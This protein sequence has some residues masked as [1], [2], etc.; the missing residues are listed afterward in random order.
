MTYNSALSSEFLFTVEYSSNSTYVQPTEKS[1][2]R[3]LNDV[4]KKLNRNQQEKRMV[5]GGGVTPVSPY[6]FEFPSWF[7]SKGKM[8]TNAIA[9]FSKFLV[10]NISLKGLMLIG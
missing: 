6:P 7:L 2:E 9:S 3:D 10:S 8:T 5:V 4:I 1:S